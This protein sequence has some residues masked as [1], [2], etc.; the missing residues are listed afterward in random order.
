MIRDLLQKKN[1]RAT[2]FKKNAIYAPPPPPQKNLPLL[3]LSPSLKCWESPKQQGRC[4][5]SAHLWATSDFVPH[6]EALETPS[7]AGLM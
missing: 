2:L 3:I 5:Q 4:S 1:K 7:M 6:S